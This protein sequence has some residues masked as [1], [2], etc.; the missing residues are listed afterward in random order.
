MKPKPPNEH[1]CLTALIDALFTNGEGAK[2][3]R[4]M[5]VSKDGRDLGGWGR[6]AVE[7]ILRD[8]LAA[9]LAQEGGPR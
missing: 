8:Y 6:T 4:L 7:L 5:L 1:G 9:I 2:A 3:E